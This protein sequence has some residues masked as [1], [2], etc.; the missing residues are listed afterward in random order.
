VFGNTGD[1]KSFTLNHTFFGGEEVFIT[2]ACQNSCTVGVWAAYDPHNSVIA[3]DTEGLL[4]ASANDNKRTRLLLKVIAISDVVVFRTRAER[5]H[6]DMFVFLSNASKAYKKHFAKELQAA[7]ERYKIKESNLGPILVV[8]QETTHTEPL[9]GERSR[10]H[11]GL[12]LL[13]P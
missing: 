2:S 7:S 13:S 10:C 1:G 12:S 4:G 11:H 6:K 5:L 9:Q 8:F 3:V